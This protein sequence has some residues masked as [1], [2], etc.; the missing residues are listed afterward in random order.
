[1]SCRFKEQNGR[2]ARKSSATFDIQLAP[3]S[4]PLEEI[5]KISS[6]YQ[7]QGFQ[8]MKKMSSKQKVFKEEVGCSTE[9]K[10]ECQTNYDTQCE[11]KYD[12]VY[13]QQCQTK[14]VRKLK[15]MWIWSYDLKCIRSKQT[16]FKKNAVL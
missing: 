15:E 9:Y 16:K 4:S 10:Q 14:Y 1:M 7:E 6:K 5:N 11:T 8:N 12:T 2:D 3:N 13:E